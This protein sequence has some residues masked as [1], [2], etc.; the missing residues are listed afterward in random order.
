MRQAE[1]KLG[2]CIQENKQAEGVRE[3]GVEE[4][5]WS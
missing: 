5:I 1:K 3:Q 2:T 4:N